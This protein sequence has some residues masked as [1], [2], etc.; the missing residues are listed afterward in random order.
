L[1][2]NPGLEQKVRNASRVGSQI[3]SFHEALGSAGGAKSFVFKFESSVAIEKDIYGR[4]DLSI[5][6]EADL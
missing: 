2:V 4:T 3:V 1:L 5:A 6:M